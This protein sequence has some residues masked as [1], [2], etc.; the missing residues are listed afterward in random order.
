[1]GLLSGGEKQRV[2][3]ARALIGSPRF[4]ILDEPFSYLDLN[5]RQSV[6]LLLKKIIDREDLPVL[7]ITHNVKW[8]KSLVSRLF[9]MK[10][11]TVLQDSK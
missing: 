3:I 6:V 10:N 8:I 9:V 5:L 7:L 1:M 2:A 11:G 4:L